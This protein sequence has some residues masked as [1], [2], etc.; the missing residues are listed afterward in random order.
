MDLNFCILKLKENVK[1]KYAQKYL[2][3]LEEAIEQ[4]GSEGLSVQL[5]Y[6]LENSRGWTGE[7]ARAVKK[8]IRKW[9]KSKNG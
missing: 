1:N 6:I 9:I 8:F 7:E 5:L 3:Q 2:E 4:G